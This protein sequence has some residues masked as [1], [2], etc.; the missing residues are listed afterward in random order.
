MTTLLQQ[1][2]AEASKLPDAEQDALGSR[3][4]AELKARATQAAGWPPGYFESTFGSITDETFERPPQG[5]Y[6]ERLELE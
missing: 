2:F 4:L 5:D 1:A 6:E 3:L